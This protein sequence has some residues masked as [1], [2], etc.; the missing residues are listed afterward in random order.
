MTISAQGNAIFGTR[1]LFHIVDVMDVIPMF[2]A[3][4]TSEIV[5]LANHALESCVERWWIFLI[6]AAPMGAILTRCVIH[7]AFMRAELSRISTGMRFISFKRFSTIKTFHSDTF[8]SCRV[9]AGHGAIFLPLIIDKKL[10]AAMGTNTCSFKRSSTGKLAFRSARMGT[11]FRIAPAW[12]YQIFFSALLANQFHFT[13]FGSF[14][15]FGSTR[16]TAIFGTIRS[17]WMH[18]KNFSTVLT[19]YIDFGFA[20]LGKKGT[21][22]T[23][24]GA[25]FRTV[26]LPAGHLPRGKKN[27]FSAFSTL[28]LS[29]WFWSRH[30]Q[31]LKR[32][33]PT[34]R[35]LFRSRQRIG[36]HG[37]K[38][39]QLT[40]RP[41]QPNYNTKEYSV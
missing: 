35:R 20:V 24:N 33:T 11:E 26:F 30:I 9:M 39:H 31:F 16:R 19:N 14:R 18:L 10:F 5:T 38:N 23:F 37:I 3:K 40:K 17:V 8:S 4:C 29:F 41:E 21:Y 34:R 22:P 27:I 7:K 25:S 1:I 36:V 12:I 2:A 32:S 13:F 6:T 28:Y 15:L